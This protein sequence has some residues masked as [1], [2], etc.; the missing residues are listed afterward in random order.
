MSSTSTLITPKAMIDT[1]V[2]CGALL[3]NG[4]NRQI[5]QAAR[6]G[7]YQPVISNVC[8]LEFVRNASNGL[9]S[10]RMKKMF[11]WETID[12]FLNL[13]VFPALKGKEVTNSIVSR[14]SYEVIKMLTKE[15]SI[16]IGEALLK[17]ATCTDFQ[18]KKIIQQHDMH[19][20]LEQFDIH[21]FHVWV[22]A[23]EEN[24]DYIVTQNTHRFPA[25]IGSITRIAPI[26]FIE[27]F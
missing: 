4:V 2:L 12:E 24:C 26:D 14:E 18:A 7:V 9:G 11:D 20:P 3:T 13:F 8:L 17:I 19:L 15:P 23:I 10:K 21:D 22:T 5:L 1:T 27:S 6:L 25:Y 16:S